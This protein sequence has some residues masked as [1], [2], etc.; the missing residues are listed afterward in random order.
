MDQQSPATRI[1][2]VTR[3][4]DAADHQAWTEFTA[5]YEPLI[6]RLLRR[7]GLQEADA[8]DVCQQVLAAVAK[9]ID[10]WRPDGRKRSFRRW[11][12]QI[13][14][15]RTLKY[16]ESQRRSQ[17]GVGGSGALAALEQARDPRESLS[18]VFEREYRQQLL[19]SACEAI[20]PEFRESTWEAFW[21]STVE[22][23]AIAE[24]AEQLGMSVGNVYV[25]RSR[26]VSRLKSKVREI[27][28]E[29]D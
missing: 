7:E 3:L 21:L 12:F 8:C 28:D 9:D 25:S 24:V 17:R 1:S 11:L 27:T 2:L 26:I 5:I 22:G 18:D 15:N 29:E 23:H 13:A 16:L 20:R 14:R 10:G 6:L 19:L 4:K